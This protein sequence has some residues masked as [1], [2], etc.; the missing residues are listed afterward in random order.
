MQHADEQLKALLDNRVKLYNQIDFIAADPIAIPH[1][2]SKKQDIEIAGLFAAVLAWG[3]RKSIINS[4][5]KLLD[6][7]DNDPHTFILHHTDKDLKKML[8]FAHRT[9]NA[10]DL[11][12]FIERLHE[13]YQHKESLESLFISPNM[14][15]EADVCNA[16]IHFHNAFFSI[17]HPV[18][19]KKHI[20]SPAKKS[21]CKRINMYLR[22][23]V[24]K[25]AAG[26]DFG[27][28]KTIKMKQ[29]LLVLS[30]LAA[31]SSY[32]PQVHWGAS[33]PIIGKAIA[34]QKEK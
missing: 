1:R 2:F 6:W 34:L 4:C 19:T 7:M 31:F 22:W 16:L 32:K 25:D 21:A 12:Y 10:T 27:I 14:E 9:F 15:Q 28:W 18:R 20:A 11:L 24:R 8:Q 29:F 23:M 5:N 26:V 13:H 17:E 33:P 3:N 30:D